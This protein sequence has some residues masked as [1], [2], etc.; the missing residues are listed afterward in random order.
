MLM[1][2]F[3]QSCAS[4]PFFILHD[5]I[6]FRIQLLKCTNKL[7]QLFL[8]CELFLYLKETLRDF[9]DEHMLPNP[10]L[11]A[12]KHSALMCSAMCL[13]RVKI[14]YDSCTCLYNYIIKLNI[15]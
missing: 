1:R 2:T 11:M 15:I 5:K 9:T 14:F 8:N 10:V 6:C 13:A 4:Y 12:S 7:Q 3:A